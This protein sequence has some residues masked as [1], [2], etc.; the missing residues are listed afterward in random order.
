MSHLADEPLPNDIMPRRITILLAAP[1]GDGLRPAREHFHEY[2]KPILVA[3]A[4]DWEV[5]E[6]RKDGDVRAGL[7]EKIRKLRRRRG[8]KVPDGT[9]TEKEQDLVRETREK[10]GIS[11]W[12]GVQGDLILGRHTWKEYIRG[13]HEGWLGPLQ[14]P[15]TAAASGL[16]PEASDDLQSDSIDAPAP[17]TEPSPIPHSPSNDTPTSEQEAEK[18]P[19]KPSKP[20]RSPPYI[21][22]TS[23]PATPTA[24]TIPET[25]SPSLPLQLPHLLGIKH[26]PTRLYRFLTRRRL[27]DDTGAQV[28]A[29]VIASRS[30][31]YTFTSSY[32]SAI[33][34]DTPSPNP[35]TSSSE[36]NVVA[37]GE[38]WEQQ[39]LL[40]DE[41]VGW[42]KSVWKEPQSTEGEDKERTWVGDIVVD[43]RIGGRMRVF[44]LEDGAGPKAE[45]LAEE[46]RTREL[47]L[48]EKVRRAVGWEKKG[49][50]G[51]EMGEEGD[52]DS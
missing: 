21:S 10:L 2:I 23:Y 22:I 34:P 45:E 47:G 48:V 1:P 42:H 7:A 52:E 20:L 31:P 18:P 39:G 36:E 19:D 4:I 14:P 25:F 30:R 17:E 24:P 26:T 6:G 51:W 32:A 44:E 37:A 11:D 40:Q 5:I 13:M 16:L 27:A 8:E 38:T 50:G 35:A 46:M 12:D 28:A 15:E 43:P 29:F 9:E 49:K 3:G 41:E 33:D